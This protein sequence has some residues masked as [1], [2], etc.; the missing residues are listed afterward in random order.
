M[1]ITALCLNSRWGKFVVIL[2]FDWIDIDTVIKLAII[3]HILL[4]I[5]FPCMEI[6]VFSL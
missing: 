4:S 2:Y 3:L 5:S 6:V 1:N